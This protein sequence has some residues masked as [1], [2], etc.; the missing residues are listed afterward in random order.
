[1]VIQDRKRERKTVGQK[2][3][4]NAN[5]RRESLQVYC[6]N[7]RKMEGRQRT[8]KDCKKW[9]GKKDITKKKERDR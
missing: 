7:I 1:M 9:K 4:G 8:L 3:G 5:K 6:R 2:E